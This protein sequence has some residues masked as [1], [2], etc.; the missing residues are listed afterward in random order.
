MKSG[1][2]RTMILIGGNEDK[3]HE[4]R[5]LAEVA[6]SARNGKIIVATLA[7]E[8]PKR[9]W[10]TYRAAFAELGVRETVHLDAET[11]EQVLD[12][13]NVDL[14]DGA[15][16]VYF[17]GGDQ[18]KLATKMGGTLLY[19]RIRDQYYDEGLVLAGTSA[20]GAAVGQTKLVGG[21]ASGRGPKK[22]GGVFM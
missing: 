21:G 15:D 8:E 22:E 6:R 17:T 10:M 11:R 20:G 18:V 3:E 12:P 14:L 2:D 4:R 7:S 9:Q 5:I 13:A 19:N 16:C 1:A